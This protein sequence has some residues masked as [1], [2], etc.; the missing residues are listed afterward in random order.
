MSNKQFGIVFFVRVFLFSAAELFPLFKFFSARAKQCHFSNNASARCFDCASLAQHDRGRGNA[1]AR[2]FD[3]LN[4]TGNFNKSGVNRLIRPF[5]VFYA[6][7]LI[8]PAFR[9]FNF[10]SFRAARLTHTLSFRA[11][12]RNLVETKTDAFFLQ[13]RK[14]RP[15]KQAGFIF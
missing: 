5:F 12:P 9:A 15:E 10:L 6:S 3:K 11:E 2:C 13:K 7:H 14:T 4:M 1:S 8:P